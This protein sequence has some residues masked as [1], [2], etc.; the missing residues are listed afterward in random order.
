MCGVSLPLP[1]FLRM[2]GL[3]LLVVGWWTVCCR[4]WT[5]EAIGRPLLWFSRERSFQSR[6]REAW[7]MRLRVHVCHRDPAVDILSRG[8]V[9]SLT[10]FEGRLLVSFWRETRGP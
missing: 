10:S 5:L 6:S 4:F 9:A 3:H 2:P 1:L 7:P 8:S